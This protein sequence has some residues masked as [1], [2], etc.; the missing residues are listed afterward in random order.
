MTRAGGPRPPTLWL[1]ASPGGH[2]AELLAVREAFEGLPRAWVTG[3]SDQVGV[4]ARAGEEIH[5]LSL[6]GRDPPGARGL[7]PNVRAARRLVGS[8]RPR[9]VVTSGAG[10]VVPFVVMARLVGARV[11]LVESLAR[12]SGASLTGRILAPF[13]D[14]ILV[15]WPELAAVYRGAVVA[16]PGLL[17]VPSPP[18]GPEHG[19]FVCVGTRPEP[20]DRLLAVADRAVADGLLPQPVTAQAGVSSYRPSSYSVTAWMAPDE[21][22]RAIA[23]S[24]YVVCHGGAAT[25][26]AAIAAGRRPLVLPRRRSAGEHRTEH[27]RELIEKLASEGMAVLVE[28]RIGPDQVRRAD[29]PPRPPPPAD[30][31]PLAEALRGAIELAA[32][33][34]RAAGA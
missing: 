23:G 4:L 30:A 19:T 11:V 21:V 16:R 33:S 32:G 18:P 27:Q 22:G 2:L 14:S 8:R 7:A 10:L 17:D 12:V 6:F 25:V 13:A 5:V 28:D 1:A 3:P 9:I 26:G 34:L 31:R 20:F 29:E 15:Q 24:R